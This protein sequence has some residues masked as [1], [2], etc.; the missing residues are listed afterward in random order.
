V[1]ELVGSRA[2]GLAMQSIAGESTGYSRLG[3]VLDSFVELGA[4]LACTAP[5]TIVLI[6]RGHAKG[7]AKN[8]ACGARNKHA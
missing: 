3:L 2:L 1:Q 8:A 6:C 7:G 4:G 5:D